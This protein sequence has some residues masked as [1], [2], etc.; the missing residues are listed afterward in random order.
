MVINQQSSPTAPGVISWAE[1]EGK[2]TCVCMCVFTHTIENLVECRDENSPNSDDI[3]SVGND[4][5]VCV[6]LRVYT[7]SYSTL[8]F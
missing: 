7:H 8:F 2:R 6:R 4:L 5:C 1:R 3:F